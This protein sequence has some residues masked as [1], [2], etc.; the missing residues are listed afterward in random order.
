MQ[1]EWTRQI[2]PVIDSKLILNHAM[3][4]SSK[5]YLV[6]VKGSQIANANTST[7]V[8]ECGTDALT[9]IQTVES[10]NLITTKIQLLAWSHEL[11]W[12]DNDN[13]QSISAWLGSNL[14]NGRWSQKLTVKKAWDK[15]SEEASQ[16]ADAD[17]TV[18]FNKILAGMKALIII[19]M[20]QCNRLDYEKARWLCYQVT[21]IIKLM[22]TRDANVDL[23]QSMSLLCDVKNEVLKRM[24]KMASS[25]IEELE[26]LEFIYANKFVVS[27]FTHEYRTQQLTQLLSVSAYHVKIDENKHQQL[28]LR[29]N[30]Q[31]GQSID[32]QEGEA[33]LKIRENT[34]FRI[35]RESS[36]EENAMNS[37]HKGRKRRF[38]APSPVRK[39]LR[40]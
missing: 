13:R 40:L 2:T 33:R 18:R 3:G 34:E 29:S 9:I 12:A 30:A 20:N 36:D 21:K 31:M 6:P 38:S 5:G 17:N 28:V 19:T 23:D 24:C 8:T 15:M 35:H 14:A 22:L 26:G 7:V 4:Q 1:T 10:W 11:E 39:R 16:N 25:V 32:G 27:T 37:Q